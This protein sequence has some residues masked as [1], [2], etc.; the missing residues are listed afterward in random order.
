MLSP[1]QRNIDLSFTV[2]P[3]YSNRSR[4]IPSIVTRKTACDILINTVIFGTGK[5]KGWEKVNSILH[6]NVPSENN[7][8][9]K[10]VTLL[11]IWMEEFEL[12]THEIWKKW[13]GL[14]E[15]AT[16]L[17]NQIENVYFRF[18]SVW[19]LEETFDRPLED[20]ESYLV[21]FVNL[22]VL[23]SSY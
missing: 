19:K 18:D 6:H 1:Y 21:I 12:I 17:F 11:E 7:R 14:Y 3:L 2:F 22:G 23:P 10:R 16:Y 4:I 15:K 9:A 8:I 13:K 5:L 20:L